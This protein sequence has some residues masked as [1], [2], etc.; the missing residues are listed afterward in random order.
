M[1]D[2]S[3]DFYFIIEAPFAG[4]D[5]GA[6]HSPALF[7]CDD[8]GRLIKSHHPIAVCETHACAIRFVIGRAIVSHGRERGV[9]NATRVPI[10]FL[11]LRA[12]DVLV[13]F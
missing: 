8:V 7:I 4:T 10:V 1:W 5:V 6:C 13:N 9:R 3:Q 12:M 11:V 2:A